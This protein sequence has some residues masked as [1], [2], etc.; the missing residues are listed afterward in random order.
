MFAEN[1][2]SKIYEYIQKYGSVT[3]AGLVDEFNV[4]VETI[5]RD[6]L[7]MEKQGMLKRVHGGAVKKSNMRAFYPLKERNK[8]FSEEKKELSLNAI[9]FINEEDVIAIDTGSTAISFA[10]VLKEHFSKLTVI[11]H[12]LDVFNI[13]CCHKEFDV[14][15]CAGHF[16]KEENSFY[17]SLVIDALSKLHAEKAFIFPSAV[18]IDCG[19]CDYH[20]NLYQI[21]KQLIKCADEIFILADSNKFETSA[22]LKLDDMRCEYQYITDGN[23]PEALESLYKENQINIFRGE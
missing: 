11:T 21:Q 19:I 14:I 18:S 5:R 12:S 23:L 3:T 13:L 10:H 17:G 15:L 16:I 22:L 8:E 20:D 2:H 9:K 1:R 7:S 6:L 4:S